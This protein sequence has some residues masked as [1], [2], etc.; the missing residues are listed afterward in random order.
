[1][2]HPIQAPPVYIKSQGQ[3]GAGGGESSPLTKLKQQGHLRASITLRKET[4]PGRTHPTKQSPNEPSDQVNV[5]V[6][7][8]TP[9]PDSSLP[10]SGGTPHLGSLALQPGPCIPRFHLGCLT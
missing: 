5:F 8:P 3:R 6:H 1:M 7:P 2:P 4:G 9:P 10:N